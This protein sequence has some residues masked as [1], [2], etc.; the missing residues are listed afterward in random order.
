MSGN[1]GFIAWFCIRYLL[2]NSTMVF[3]AL[4]RSSGRTE[5]SFSG[6]FCPLQTL[7]DQ[8]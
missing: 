2:T 4:R 5:F 6:C 1:P 8:K 7:K 3:G